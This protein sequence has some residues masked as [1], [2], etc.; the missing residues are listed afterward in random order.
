MFYVKLIDAIGVCQFAKHTNGKRVSAEAKC[1]TSLF[2]GWNSHTCSKVVRVGASRG[3]STADDCE[4]RTL[5]K[6][7]KKAVIAVLLVICGAAPGAAEDSFRRDVVPLLKKYCFDCHGTSQQE[8]ELN[9]Q[10]YD[11]EAAALRQRRTW[12]RVWEMLHTREMPPLCPQN[13]GS[14]YDSW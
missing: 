8:A 6:C 7:M 11:S 3:S 2:V 1:R 4:A 14:E 10:V 12:K 9:L 5:D 13:T